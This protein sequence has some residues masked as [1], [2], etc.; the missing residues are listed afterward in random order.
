MYYGKTVHEQCNHLK[1]YERGKFADEWG[2]TG[3]LYKLGC[4]GMD[5]GCDIPT[6][7]WVGGIN[8]CTA[9]G[10]GCIGCTEDV[11]P[12]Y[13]KRGLF[14]HLH[15]SVDEINK[16]ENADIREAVLKLKKNGGII[17]G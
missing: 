7:K 8:S 4:I 9:C 3:C 5:S 14:K 2:D 15:A 1:D 17:H 13:G 16:I 10:A 12:D 11:F 6:R